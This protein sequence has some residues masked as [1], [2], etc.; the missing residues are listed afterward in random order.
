MKMAVLG[1]G[2]AGLSCALELKKHN[3]QIEVSVF[4]KESVAGGLLQCTYLDGHQWDN[5][6]F[7]FQNGSHLHQLMPD[8]FQPIEDFSQ[9][10]FLGLF[11]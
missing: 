6:V 11:K 2:I 1:A 3:P 10:I 8:I 9:E 5:G 4:E 7:M